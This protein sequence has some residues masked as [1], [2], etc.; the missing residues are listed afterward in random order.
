M[1]ESKVGW[2]TLVEGA[3]L[4]RGGRLWR[5]GIPQAL[6]VSDPY[7][8]R[9]KGDPRF[10]FSGGDPPRKAGSTKRRRRKDRSERLELQPKV[11]QPLPNP[12]LKLDL[13]PEFVEGDDIDRDDVTPEDDGDFN[14]GDEDAASE[15]VSESAEYKQA[16]QVDFDKNMERSVL[17]AAAKVLGA[18][19]P[20]GEP[21]SAAK[22]RPILCKWIRDR[23]QEL[24]AGMP[25]V[26]GP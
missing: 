14:D 1:G 21:P 11:Q 5:R 22:T 12:D 20:N 18:H 4:T 25:K 9:L 24:V 7:Y 10:Q 19:G 3:T 13:S 26:V 17:D 15:A 2:F 23:Q 16:L 8:D 6:S